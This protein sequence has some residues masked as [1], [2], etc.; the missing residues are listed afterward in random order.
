[1]L[2]KQNVLGKPLPFKLKLTYSH[3]MKCIWIRSRCLTLLTIPMLKLLSSKA[4]GC[5]DFWKPSKPCH[6]GIH[7]IALFEHSQMS[8]H[9][10][11]CQSFFRFFS[12]CI[13]K[14][15]RQYHQ[16]LEYLWYDVYNEMYCLLLLIHITDSNLF[17]YQRM[18]HAV[19]WFPT[20]LELAGGTPGN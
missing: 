16:G 7:K 1:M 14:I 17:I 11:R 12:L 9:V 10:P 4:Q 3:A 19:D 18:I 20:F 2:K 6:V 8:T 15:S 13:G 5:E